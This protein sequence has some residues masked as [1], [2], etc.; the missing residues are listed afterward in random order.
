MESTE[1]DRESCAPLLTRCRRL[2]RAHED[3]LLQGDEFHY[4]LMIILIHA[5]DEDAKFG[6]RLR[7]CWGTCLS[8]VPDELLREFEQWMKREVAAVD[9]MPSP[10][11]FLADTRS[12]EQIEAKRRELRPYFVA[13][14]DLL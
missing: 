5:A 7:E 12:L 8:L 10:N 2:L 1:P 13:L 6:T 9:Y 11:P 4:N 3:A 14:H